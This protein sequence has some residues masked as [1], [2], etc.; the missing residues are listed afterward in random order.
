LRRAAPSN[1][2]M[3]WSD[4]L[5]LVRRVRAGDEAAFGALFDRSFGA[6]YRFALRRLGGDGDAAED[7]AQ[8]TL[9]RAIPR[10]GGY[11]G[12]ASLLT[13]LTTICRHELADRGERQRRRPAEV[14]LAEDRPEVRAALE[15]LAADPER[16][17]ERREV[18]DRVHLALDALPSGY[19]RALE[20]KYLEERSVAEIAERLGLGTKA[21]E[22][23]LTRARAA[24]RDAFASLG[25]AEEGPVT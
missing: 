25:P 17:L 10:L 24:F 19:A 4:D 18:T 8:A 9:T 7:V 21:A 3:D 1:E 5:A 23:L 16:A 6:L 11:R 22:S 13:W 15:S 14:E 2:A 20:W 12:E